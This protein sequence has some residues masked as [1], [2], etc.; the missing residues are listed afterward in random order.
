MSENNVF[1]R[2][3]FGIRGIREKKFEKISIRENYT[4]GKQMGES[5]WELRKSS[6]RFELSFFQ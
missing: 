1:R 2:I 5:V 4:Q 3:I 6:L